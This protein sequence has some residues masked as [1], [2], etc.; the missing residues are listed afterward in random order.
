MRTHSDAADSFCGC[1]FA[2]AG[3]A[4]TARRDVFL[5]RRYARR[6]L[7]LIRTRCCCPME[8][9]WIENPKNA[10]SIETDRALS[11]M[12]DSFARLC[13][14]GEATRVIPPPDCNA[15]RGG[16]CAN[17]RFSVAALKIIIAFP[18]DSLLKARLWRKGNRR[19]S[20]SAPEA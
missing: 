11:R 9:L 18:R 13:C 14:Q 3:R 7:R 4:A 20:R 19:F 10:I 17:N 1:C 8:S 5:R 2:G 6:R 15:S 16:N 12:P